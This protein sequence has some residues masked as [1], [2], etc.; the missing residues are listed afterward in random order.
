M[1][2][3]LADRMRPRNLDDV[4]GQEHITGP[5]T[6]IRAIAAQPQ[7]QTTAVLLYGPPG[8]GKTSI[9][10]AIAATTKREFISL[11][12]TTTTAKQLKDLIASA[13]KSDEEPPIVF[14]DE[15]HHFNKTQ[16]DILLPAIEK[17][18]IGFIGATTENPSFTLN[19]ALTSRC[20]LNVLQPLDTDAI[21]R[22][23]HHA[24]AH[25]NGLDNHYTIDDDAIHTI[26]RRSGGDTRAALTHLDAAATLAQSEN[27]T[28]ITTQHVT[29]VTTAIASR[30][31]ASGDEHYNII[32]AMIKS[33]RDSDPDAAVYWLARLIDSGEDPRFIARRL[34]IHAS[35]DVGLAQSN[36]LHTCIAAAHAVQLI[37]LPEARINLAHAAITIATAPKSNS[38][39]K[40][41]NTALEAVKHQPGLDVPNHLKDAHYKGA[42]ALG[43][44]VDYIYPHNLPGHVQKTP[45]ANMPADLDSRYREIYTPTTNGDEAT[46]TQRLNAIERYQRSHNN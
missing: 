25:P 43:H 21:V 36:V 16:Q 32:S 31:D 23:I 30:Y 2:Q 37:G 20:I 10:S 38:V 46:I 13:E 9:A 11:S 1:T 19:S 28:A 26:A 22:V 15:I 12:A 17:G 7:A 45:Q 24:L 5:G 18:V 34:V 40:S 27:S 14:I 6:M 41:I 35:E 44:G 8:T 4:I 42:R 3:P 29:S 39:I 33:M